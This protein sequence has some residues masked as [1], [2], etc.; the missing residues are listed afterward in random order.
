MLLLE[1]LLLLRPYLKSLGLRIPNNVI[2]SELDCNSQGIAK[3]Y[4]PQ[5]SVSY[6]VASSLLLNESSCTRIQG[7]LVSL[8]QNYLLSHAGSEYIIY[9]LGDTIQEVFRAALEADIFSKQTVVESY[10]EKDIL[11]LK[12]T[13]GPS[14]YKILASCLQKEKRSR[15]KFMVNENYVRELVQDYRL[16]DAEAR[17]ALEQAGEIEEALLVWAMRTTKE[18]IGNDTSDRDQG[19][20]SQCGTLL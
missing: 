9:H 6:R 11:A 14:I 5:S 3:R 4:F 18:V 12:C 13:E 8:T 17:S 19:V 10:D 1:K 7:S 15:E 20:K 16:T 2:C